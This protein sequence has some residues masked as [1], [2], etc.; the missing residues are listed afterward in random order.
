MTRLLALFVLLLAS[1]AAAQDGFIP[2]RAA[3]ELGIPSEKLRRVEE[4]AYAANEE[5][6]ELEAAVRRAQMA[7]DRELRAQPPEEAKLVERIDALTKADGA[8]RRNRILLLSRVR[9]ALGEE[10]WQ[11]LE[12]WREQNPPPG[13]EGQRP[14]RPGPGEGPGGPR[15]GGPGP[16]F[17]G[18]RPGGEDGP[19]PRPPR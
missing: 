18:E 13:R 11:R 9:R 4:L 17:R 14:G 8:M 2:P 1:R 6:I 10:L 5:A 19:G 16:R 3:S 7:L 12:G 15:P